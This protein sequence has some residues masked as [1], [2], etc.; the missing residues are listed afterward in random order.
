MT[1]AESGEYV[2]ELTD[3]GEHYLEIF[4]HDDSIAAVLRHAAAKN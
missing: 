1:V 3:T 2:Y 4:V